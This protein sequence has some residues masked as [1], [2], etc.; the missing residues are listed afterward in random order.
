MEVKHTLNY[1]NLCL[2]AQVLEFDVDAQDS[3]E[4]YIKKAIDHGANINQV[5]EGINGDTLLHLSIREERIKLIAALLKNGANPEIRNFAD[6][7]AKQLADKHP[8][9]RGQIIWQTAFQQDVKFS[10]T[11]DQEKLTKEFFDLIQKGNIE[12]IKERKKDKFFQIAMLRGTDSFGRTGIHIASLSGQ[13]RVLGYLMSYGFGEINK[14][15]L[16]GQTPL[17]LAASSGS[18]KT[19]EYLIQNGADNH[20]NDNNWQ[21]PLHIAALR[22]DI[23]IFVS[24]IRRFDNPVFLEQKDKNGKTAYDLSIENG[25]Q[26]IAEFL[27]SK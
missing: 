14:K 10:E 25:H 17:H 18:K 22:G 26:Y 11:G 24:L 23:N 9:L 15:D 21:T 13:V 8:K 12:E 19:V 16:N 2:Y 20:A 6:L 1:Q 4:K 7:N 5:V 3:L 27:K